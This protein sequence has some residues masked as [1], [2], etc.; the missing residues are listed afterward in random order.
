ML[1]GSEQ[2]EMEPNNIIIS[3]YYSHEH[4]APFFFAGGQV[5]ESESQQPAGPNFPT[6][7]II[8]RAAEQRA[9]PVNLSH[10]PA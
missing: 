1:F 5:G 10:W 8:A 6:R 9:C 7:I 4:P 3:Y 2:N